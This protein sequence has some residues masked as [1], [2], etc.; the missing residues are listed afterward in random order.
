MWL[1]Y[2]HFSSEIV[3]TNIFHYAR[4]TALKMFCH[5]VL[6]VRPETLL[7]RYLAEYLTHFHQTCNADALW[8][9][10]EQFT[11]CGQKVKDQGHG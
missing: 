7:T 8:D 9:T 10:G 4:E 6:Y 1:R 2:E 5:I 11:I 3:C